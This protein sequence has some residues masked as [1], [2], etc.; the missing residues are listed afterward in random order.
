MNFAHWQFEHARRFGQEVGL[1]FG[2]RTWTNAELH[3]QAL[4]LA[5][6]LVSFGVQPG[7]RVVLALGNCAELFVAS[8]AAAIAGAVVV[9]L[10][11]DLSE[12]LEQKVAHCMP[13]AVVVA[14]ELVEA[15]R[16]WKIPGICISV[17]AERAGSALDFE[18][19]IA[20]HREIDAPVEL[21]PEAFAQLCY[22]GGSTG[23]PKAVAYTHGGVD[24]FLRR[25]AQEVA[26]P[27]SLK[28]ALL[29][30]PPTAFG[31][32]LVPLRLTANYRYIVLPHFEAE[33]AL[34]AI[35]EQGVQ[36]TSLLPTMAELLVAC[37]R[38]LAYDCSS[39]R[40]INIGGSHVPA[41]LISD[42]S[43]IFGR[44]REPAARP[45]IAVHYGMTETG[46]GFASTAEGG[47]GIVGRIAPGV[48]VR[49][50]NSDGTDA[51]RGEVG[52]I[53]VAAPFAA[54]GYWQD[55]EQTANVFRD[56]FVHTGDLGRLRED[57][58]L[59]LLGRAKD[60]ILQGGTNVYP[61]ELIKVIYPISGVRECAVVGVPD[62]LLGE[63]VVVCVSRCEGSDVS[64]EQI[65]AAC[66]RSL[67]PR[68]HPVRILF[69]DELPKSQAGKVEIAKL[70][71][72]VL[73]LSELRPEAPPVAGMSLEDAR[74]V[75]IQRL[76][77]IL[78]E[79]E[80]LAATGRID[81][82]ATFGELGLSSRGAVRLAHALSQAFSISV[83]STIAYSHPTID[84]CA[85][86]LVNA[87]AGRS[88]R[89]APVTDA[90]KRPEEVA[91]VGMGV[92]LPGG[93][94]TPDEFWEL[95]WEGRDTVCDAP[96]ERAQ[97]VQ[98]RWR[99]AFLQNAADFD[100]AFFRL[101]AQAAELD[102]R[103]RHLLEVCWE[104]LEHAG[105]SPESV[106]GE[107]TG[108]FLGLYGQRYSGPNPLG[109]ATGMS[110]GY[111]CQFFDFQGPVLC[112]DT[113]CSSSLVAIHSAVQ[114]LRR[115][116]CDIAIA[117]GANLLAEAGDPFG[118]MATDG[119]TRAFDASANGF[120]QG[121]GCVLLVLK[122]LSDARLSNDRVL[123]TILS[124]AINHDGRSSSLTAP[125]PRSQASVITLAVQAAGIAQQ[126]V[127]Y[128]EAHGTGTPLGDPIEI[129]GIV[130][131]LAA[132]RRSPLAIGSVKTNIGH[133]EAAAGVAGIA[134][135]ALAIAH[136][137]L[138]ASL[139]F[140]TPNPHIPWERIPLRVQS[141]NGPWPDPSARLIAGVSSFGMSG[142]NAHAV[143]AEGPSE[144]NH[145]WLAGDRQ[146]PSERRWLLPISASSA[147]ALRSAVRAWAREL[148]IEASEVTCR[149]IAYSASCRRSHLP[150]RM[151][152]TG[153]SRAEWAQKLLRYLTGVEAAAEGRSPREP[154]RLALVF[155]GQGS[156]WAG[157]ARDLRAH[158]PVFRDELAR[159]S[160]L[161][162]TRVQWSLLEELDREGGSS[163]L[164]D[165]EVC[166]PALFAM[167]VALYELLRSWG[168]QATAAV[169][170]SAGEIAAAYVSGLFTLD[171]AVALV[172]ERG[173]VCRKAYGG[174]MLAASLS[175]AHAGSFC[176]QMGGEIEIA[177]INGPNS[178]V[179]SGAR[180]SIER[181]THQL[182]TRDIPL[183]LLPVHHAFHSRHMQ[184][185]AEELR[186]VLSEIPV[187]RAQL[188]LVSAMTGELATRLDRAYW[189]EHLVHR[190]R[191]YDA[192]R[193]LLGEGYTAFLEIS[194]HA[195]LLPALQEIFDHHGGD[196][197]PMAVG[198][199]V[200]GG[201][202][203]E[204]LLQSL[205][206]LHCAG[207]AVDWNRRYAIRGRLA[208]MPRYP[209]EH[210]AYW[211]SGAAP[212]EGAPATRSEALPTEGPPGEL[213]ANAT[214]REEL[215]SLTER[216]AEQLPDQCALEELGI[217]SL[218]LMRLRTRLTRRFGVPLEAHDVAPDTTIKQLAAA[219][220]RAGERGL[221]KPAELVVRLRS[222]KGAPVHIWLH[223][224]GGGV[225]CY[226]PLARSLP[227]R[228]LAIESP[229]LR[230]DGNCPESVE[231]IASHYIACLERAG[232]R[233][234]LVLAGWSFGGV[235]A[236]EMALQL[237][238][239]GGR[240]F[241]VIMIDSYVGQEV[242][243]AA[244]DDLPLV[245]DLEDVPESERKR[246]QRLY[247]AH[248]RAL[249][250]YHPARY[251]GAVVSIRATALGGDPDR[252]WQ[253]SAPNLRVHRLQADHF[254]IMKPS[255]HASLVSALVESRRA[256]M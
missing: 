232:V 209:W 90:A 18:Q 240:A 54:W 59:C 194:P 169:G 95:L 10:E 89:E 227:Y 156:L 144:P 151:A 135:V 179:L 237:M 173:R 158:E 123:A 61:A 242:S 223:P 122:R 34:R 175:A 62:R 120:G 199:L 154:R 255:L 238:R 137:L 239:S 203:E 110:A 63:E 81:E 1:V 36:E 243:P 200:R 53:I 215:A 180:E 28:I 97:R 245:D 72:G 37:P 82:G 47:D 157:M 108:L 57:G 234:S 79:E 198:S 31:S 19:V 30:A 45:R 35:Q 190:V 168:I 235:V 75:L 197:D 58:Q 50:I 100:G 39:V 149:D 205:G 166:Q 164:A 87:P 88:A 185:A 141:C 6:A 22:T 3:R 143:L 236:F 132:G 159:I 160:A 218:G 176:S 73:K 247:R 233:E 145:S 117:G 21:A 207:V 5:S 147:T 98:G 183:R 224:A 67:D 146:V 225:D 8:A 193:T 48:R 113:T 125:N 214:L 250:Q 29:G 178:V 23:R 138:P 192:V 11:D 187:R 231:E 85:T 170:H 71:H 65:R 212:T 221:T 56:G 105:C 216:P 174:A 204:S 217:D 208:R 106:R 27:E 171:E 133:L 253:A 139:H 230:S 112:V 99:A 213:T 189:C 2:T 191:F 126:R 55:A 92:R 249:R 222:G 162:D 7:D 77:V 103:H 206:H 142:T 20:G 127:Q 116:E 115:L 109:C 41:A 150:F 43:E 167:Q 96:P 254:S 226:R 251:E 136:R 165:T 83:P 16:R 14:G 66:R 78:R 248:R 74:A 202:P 26:D 196:A 49:I 244:T 128:V 211:L 140:S 219:L 69:F 131:S 76:C 241:P 119:R 91:I 256:S 130:S 152:V 60:V 184:S 13:V 195:V 186:S 25:M 64:E 107:R 51:A 12:E 182:R 84:A 46:G 148:E 17:G 52:E 44:G 129:E 155:S 15:A 181:A 93:V 134:K 153:G 101:S 94:H 177:A 70:R 24:S 111:L 9:V 210:S 86:W 201:A 102:P 163:R 80:M 33:A 38:K 124:T 188:R 246:L 121:E 32:R 252:I 104:A 118:V 42:L 68:K 228:S 4:R 114:S 161:I 229:G 172:C 40:S 220:S